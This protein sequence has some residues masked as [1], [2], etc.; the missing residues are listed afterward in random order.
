M[1]VARGPQCSPCTVIPG[2]KGSSSST[3]LLQ[4]TLSLLILFLPVS[5]SCWLR[6]RRRGGGGTPIC[7]PGGTKLVSTQDG[8]WVLVATATTGSPQLPR[9]ESLWEGTDLR[10]RPCGIPRR[11][12]QSAPV[13][14][15]RG[16]PRAARGS[17][18]RAVPA[19][20]PRRAAL[21]G[22]GTPQL[23]RFQR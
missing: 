2:V 13:R 12:S 21:L 15:H 6:V 8:C 11:S 7:S 23:A 18:A 5:P 9:E 10:L 4:H 22:A 3:A 19:A 1:R 20:R 17:G 14:R 16:W